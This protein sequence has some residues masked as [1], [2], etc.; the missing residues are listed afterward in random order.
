MIAA[1]LNFQSDELVTGHNVVEFD[2]DNHLLY[3]TD[4]FNPPR[5]I[6]IEKSKNGD[7]LEPIK[8]EVI[9][10]IKYP[11]LSPPKAYYGTSI[12]SSVSY[13]ND[14]VWQFKAA[15]V[16]D[17]K[18]L[19]AFS[20]ISIQILPSSSLRGD[21]SDNFIRITVSKGGDLVERVVI[22]GRDGNINDFF[23]V[24]RPRYK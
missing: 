22:A 6:N 3:F 18:E 17:D 19:S 15:Y 13:L 9:D 14:S 4:G 21:F 20:P 2:K 8:E 11:P 5:K 10:A 24:N 16:Y 12:N 7:Y 1:V 23:R